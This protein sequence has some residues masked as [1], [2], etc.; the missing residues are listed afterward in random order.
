MGL[1]TNR[2]GQG[3]LGGTT[4][5]SPLVIQEDPKDEHEGNTIQF[6]ISDGSNDVGITDD[7]ITMHDAF[8]GQE[9]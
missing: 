3:K 4:S 7:W 6:G 2:K 5:W 1:K 9:Q 8:P